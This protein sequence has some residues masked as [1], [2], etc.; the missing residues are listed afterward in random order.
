VTRDEVERMKALCQQ[1]IIEKDQAKFSQIL[2]ELNELLEQKNKRLDT[3]PNT[4]I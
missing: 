4:K 2:V 1:I 3:P